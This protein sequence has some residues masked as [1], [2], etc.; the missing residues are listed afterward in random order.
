MRDLEKAAGEAHTAQV[1]FVEGRG[2]NRRL[3]AALVVLALAG[4]P[5][6]GAGAPPGYPN[7]PLE[8]IIPFPPGG[9]A[10]TAARII[11]PRLWAAVGVPI[12]LVNKPGGG[13]TRRS[14]G[15]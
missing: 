1:A 10:D 5:A 15:A 12:V 6:L 14:S 7:R 13:G 9:P 3:L 11:Q 4:L 8:F 2:M